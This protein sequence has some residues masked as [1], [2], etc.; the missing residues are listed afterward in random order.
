[1]T[2]RPKTPIVVDTSVLINFLRVDR[3]D[4]FARHPDFE[5]LVTEHVKAE[6]T[7]NYPQ[8]L[9]RL[10]DGCQSGAVCEISVNNLAELETFNTLFS[11]KRLGA[12]EC[13][14]IAAAYHRGLLIAVDDKQAKK[15]AH[16]L[17]KPHSVLDTVDLMVFFI[18][19]GLLDVAQADEIKRDWE[20]NHRFRLPF[21]S[22]QQKISP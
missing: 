14:A 22:F 6:V 7:R 19:A 4:L 16:R 3:L 12:G 9:Q 1:M 17:C 20:A 15:A 10:L 21:N 2:H 8:Q 13:A 11:G 5:F 18:R